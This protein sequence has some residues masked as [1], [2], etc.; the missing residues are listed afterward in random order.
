[1]DLKG[2]GRADAASRRADRVPWARRGEW[3]LGN[4]A[5]RPCTGCTIPQLPKLNYCCA[6]AIAP[7]AGAI[8][9]AAGAT[10]SAGTSGSISAASASSVVVPEMVLPLT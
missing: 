10:K 3:Q 1:R 2:A 4:E 7:P 6:G 8:A 5:V 9:S